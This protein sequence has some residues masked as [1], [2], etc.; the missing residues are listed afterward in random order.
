MSLIN[1][2]QDAASTSQGSKAINIPIRNNSSNFLFDL[3]SSTA[4][5]GMTINGGLVCCT[6]NIEKMFKP[7]CV[8]L[9][10]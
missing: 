9:A 2:N 7:N 6:S 3:F 5:S 1:I 8:I 10:V 4:S